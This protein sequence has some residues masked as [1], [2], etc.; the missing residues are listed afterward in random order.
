MSDP[1]LHSG[2]G[3][4]MRIVPETGGGSGCDRNAALLFLGHPVHGGRSF[5]G[6]TDAVVLSCIEQDPFGGSG[7]SGIDMS[8]NTDVPDSF[9]WM[10]SGHTGLLLG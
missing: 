8:H 9:K 10:A 2:I 5:V 4:I 3:R 1:V 7:F 6:F